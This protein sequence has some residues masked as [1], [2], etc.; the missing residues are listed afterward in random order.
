MSIK[1]KLVFSNIAMCLIPLIL[2][3]ITLFG[4]NN[5]YS[6]KLKSYYEVEDMKKKPLLNPYIEL[7][8]INIRP[9]KELQSESEAIPDNFEDK[10][11]LKTI[12]EALLKKNTYIIV[13]KSGNVVFNG[14]KKN[15]KDIIS[16]LD[17]LN[18]SRNADRPEPPRTESISDD[19]ETLIRQ[20]TFIFSDGSSGNVFLVADTSK[21]SQ[22]AT[23]FIISIIIAIIAIISL[24]GGFITFLVSRSILIP[25]NQLKIG[26]EK[27]KH[28]NLDFKVR[29]ESSDEIG[30]L[31]DAFDSMRKKLKESVELQAQYENN[32]KELISNISHD[33]KTPI[34]SI[35]GYIEGIRDGVADTPEKMEKY[36]NTIYNKTQSMNYLIEELLTYS[37][38]DLKKLPFYFIDM[39]FVSYMNDL[40]EEFKFDVEKNN[41]E[42]SYDNHIKGKA[43]VRIDVQ[44]INRVISNIISN[45]IKYMDKEHGK[46]S[47]EVDSNNEEVLVGIKDNGMGISE[48]ALPYVFDRFYREDF[49]RNTSKGGSGLGLAICKKIIEEHGGSIWAKSQK[50]HGTEIWFSIKLKNRIN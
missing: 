8:S 10:K 50:G 6:R 37:K 26:T 24:T 48:E 3:L 20:F 35:K 46:I 25:L 34:T 40:M 28:G 32:R 16:K 41:M 2:C 5:L 36:V 45:S 38:L 12:N 15:N 19:S 42:F 18:Y 23:E 29:A 39:D 27:I 47:V 1:T 13:E 9:F 43:N 4:L 31:C 17:D 14:S 11:V 49:S 44:N 21:L 30:E 22:L 7:K 33:L